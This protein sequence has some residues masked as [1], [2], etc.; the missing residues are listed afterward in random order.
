[1]L[2]ASNQTAN[3]K[4]KYV[5]NL[6]TFDWINIYNIPWTICSLLPRGV[7]SSSLYSIWSKLAT[8]VDEI[9][10]LIIQVDNKITISASH[11]M[12]HIK[13]HLAQSKHP[14][15]FPNSKSC[16]IHW[17]KIFKCQWEKKVN[18]FVDMVLIQILWV[19]FYILKTK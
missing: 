13:D 4:C 16:R 6:S 7:C 17:Q 8:R 9:F 11:I 1:M 14:E 19:N 3:F 18:K 5:Q 12:V 10:Y 15:M 2:D